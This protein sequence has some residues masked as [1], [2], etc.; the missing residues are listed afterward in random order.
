MSVCMRVVGVYVML[1]N[2]V[3][4]QHVSDDIHN[5]RKLESANEICVVKH[6]SCIL[7]LI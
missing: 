1:T 3:V 6:N 2:V 7:G 4:K 5:F